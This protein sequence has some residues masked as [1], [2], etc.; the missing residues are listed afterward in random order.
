VFFEKRK[1]KENNYKL[2]TKCGGFNR[3]YK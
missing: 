2:K 3:N 1:K